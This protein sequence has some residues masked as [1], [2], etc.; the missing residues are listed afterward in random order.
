MFKVDTPVLTVFKPVPSVWDPSANWLAPLLI[1][2]A[3]VDK[4]FD[5]FNIVE[6]LETK[7]DVPLYKSEAPESNAL[8]PLINVGVCLTSNSVP[9]ANSWL[10]LVKNWLFAVKSFNPLFI[11]DAPAK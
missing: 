10:P 6:L 9:S 4:A 7:A 1:W 3:P 8:T 11:C 5:P 2:L